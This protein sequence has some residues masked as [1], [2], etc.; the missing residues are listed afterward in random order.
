MGIVKLF[1]W[2]TTK[3]NLTI[4]LCHQYLFYLKKRGGGFEIAKWLTV[5]MSYVMLPSDAHM[6]YDLFIF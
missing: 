5:G 4:S 6:A 3:R 2:R 1:R